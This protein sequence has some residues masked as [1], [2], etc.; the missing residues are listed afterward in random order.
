MWFQQLVPSAGFKLVSRSLF[1]QVIPQL[2][3]YWFPAAGSLSRFPRLFPSAGFPQVV[4]AQLVPS[5]GLVL[6]SR[7]WLPRLVSSALSQQVSSAGFRRWFPAAG[8]F[9]FPQL[10]SRRAFPADG[11]LS[12]FP[13]WVARSWF[14]A[15]GFLLTGLGNPR[16]AEGALR[17]SGEY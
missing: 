11:F 10:V 9:S 1:R 12:W 5:A 16:E 13:L 17:S 15:A 3:S 2:A 14:H 8:F 6:F 7:S 4:V